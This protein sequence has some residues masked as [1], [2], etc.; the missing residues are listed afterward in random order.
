MEESNTPKDVPCCNFC[1]KTHQGDNK[2]LIQ[3]PVRYKTYICQDCITISNN[4]IA[5]KLRQAPKAA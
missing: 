4:V 1:D 2:L 3:S 5:A